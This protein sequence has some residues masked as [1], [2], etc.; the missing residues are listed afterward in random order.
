[1]SRLDREGNFKAIPVSWGLEDNENTESIAVAIQFKITAA[2]DGG[3]WIDWTPYEE[4]TIVGRF[5]VVKADGTINQFAVDS[6]VTALGWD[7]RTDNME[8]G[9]PAVECQLTTANE[10]WKGKVS[11]KVKWINHVNY[12][13][14]VGGMAADK[15][16][17]VSTRFGSLLRAAAAEA[18]KNNPVSESTGQAPPKSVAEQDAEDAP[19]GH[20]AAKQDL[21]F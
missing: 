9:P 16:A 13:P 14:G 20:P 7:G 12:S 8:A 19:P 4:Q 3:E 17:G 2:H 15:V 5:Y 10:E 18:R 1:M 6:L 11:L 21:P